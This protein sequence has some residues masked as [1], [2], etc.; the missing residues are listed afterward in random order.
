MSFGQTGISD[1]NMNNFDSLVNDFITT[2]NIPGAS[3]AMAKDGKLI[4]N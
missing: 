4:Y 1:P 3:M 2:H